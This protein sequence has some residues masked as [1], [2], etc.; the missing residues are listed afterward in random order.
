MI[1]QFARFQLLIVI[2]EIAKPLMINT[3]SCPSPDALDSVYLQFQEPN[4]FAFVAA[5]PVHSSPPRLPPSLKLRR[6]SRT[7]RAFGNPGIG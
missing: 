4:S 5:K 2:G 1:K 7:R 6:T 3:K